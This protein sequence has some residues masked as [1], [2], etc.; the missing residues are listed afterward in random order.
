MT[1]YMT[2]S[3]EDGRSIKVYISK[4]APIRP[5]FTIVA[6]PDGVDTAAFYFGERLG[7]YCGRERRRSL[8]SGTCGRWLEGGV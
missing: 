4:E 2:K 7:G 1:G 8:Y 5:Y 3:F 6:V